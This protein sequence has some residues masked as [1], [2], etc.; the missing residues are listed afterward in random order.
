MNVPHNWESSGSDLYELKKI[1]GIHQSTRNMYVVLVELD[2]KVQ[3]VNSPN[4]HI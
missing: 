4:H 2:K 3:S 1:Q